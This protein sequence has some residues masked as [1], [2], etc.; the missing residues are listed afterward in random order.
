M[1][2]NADAGT[3]AVSEERSDAMT[4]LELLTMAGSLNSA[5]DVDFLLQRIGAAAE[6]LLD[7]EASSIMLVSKDGKSLYFKVASGEKGQALKTMTLP[8]G[9]GI[10]GWVA[11]NRRPEIVNDVQ[12]DPHFAAEYD[13]ASGF[14]TRSVLAVPMLH[15]GELVGVLEVLNKREG[16][17]GQEHLG[18]LTRLAAFASASIVNTRTISEQ[19]NFFSHVLELLSVAT[20]STMPGMSGHS[21]RAA[22]LARALGRALGMEDYEY[23]QLYYAAMLHDVGYIA[24]NNQEV[25]CDMGI[26]KVSEDVHPVLSAKM[27][28]GITLVEGAVPLILHHHERW[29]GKGYPDKLEG[30]AIP[31]GSR[32]LLLVETVEELRMIGLRGTELYAKAM[33][34]AREGS[35][36]SFDPRVA[37]AFIDI[38]QSRTT[39]W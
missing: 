25:L 28:E 36:K 21:A 9:R 5:I 12:N 26:R 13:K 34:E 38:I 14:L 17:Y 31:L 3:P 32:I 10:G 8:L 27:L 35:G 30:E 6:R 33:Q 39:A 29:D 16:E 15:R 11:Q 24:L 4:T 37:Q 7:S 22:K 1:N 20:E 18:L 2:D 19:Q 23:R